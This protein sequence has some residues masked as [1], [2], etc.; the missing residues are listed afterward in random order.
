MKTQ[1]GWALASAMLLAGIG[2]ASAAD[3]AVKAPPPPPVAVWSWTGFYIGAHGGG[4]WAD[5]DWTERCSVLLPGACVAPENPA[6]PF[7][8][9]H[10]VTSGIAGGQIGY[11]WQVSQW[12]FGVQADASG[13]WDNEECSQIVGNQGGF[14]AIQRGAGCSSINWIASVTGRAGIAFGHAL[15]YG[16]GGVAFVDDRFFARCTVTNGALPTCPVGTVMTTTASDTRVGG[17]VGVG[18]EY[19]FNMNWSIFG[20][21]DYMD[22]G[23]QRENLT[24]IR[25]AGLPADSVHGIDIRQRVNVAKFGINYR[26]GGP[27]VAKY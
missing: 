5:K 20:E 22:F 26:F 19:A 16:K 21:Y 10:T 15:L 27:V 12:V 17:T 14:F 23:T 25:F 9:S 3:M 2:S 1:F 6:A 7:H 24:T 13:A 8:T 4:L 18:I 11:N